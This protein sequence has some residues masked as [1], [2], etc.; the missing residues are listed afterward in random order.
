[1]SVVIVFK[2]CFKNN[3]NA[4]N[5]SKLGFHIMNQLYNVYHYAFP[6]FF[7]AIRSK[8]KADPP[9]SL[10]PEPQVRLIPAFNRY[11]SDM[12]LNS[13]TLHNYVSTP[14]EPYYNTTTTIDTDMQDN[15]AYCVSI[16]E[17]GATH[18]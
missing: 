17:E 18:H 5:E 11:N 13:D 16:N 1:M 6:F 2:I 10:P 9:L 4:S 15:P 12:H 8:I 14:D 7:S 3:Q